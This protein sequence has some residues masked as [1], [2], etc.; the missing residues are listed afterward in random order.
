[1]LQGAFPATLMHV[2]KGAAIVDTILQEQ[3]INLKVG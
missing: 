2:S 1:M 3:G